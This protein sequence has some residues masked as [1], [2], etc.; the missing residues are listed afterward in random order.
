MAVIRLYDRREMR[1]RNPARYLAPIV[2]LATVGATYVIVHRALM[3]KHS[4]SSLHA[5]SQPTDGPARTKTA[6]ARRP[7]RPRFY[8]VKPGD[9]LS[10]ISAKTGV[11]VSNLELLNPNID[12]NVLQTG[13]RLRLRQ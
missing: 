3:T 1:A 9:T 2:L 10:V 7:R 11:S 4:T 5:L 12:P 6:P 13:Q 8:V